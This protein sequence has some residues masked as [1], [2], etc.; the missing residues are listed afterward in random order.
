MQLFL[1]VLVLNI[2]VICEYLLKNGSNLN[3]VVVDLSLFL[4]V[5]HEF[6]SHI[7]FYDSGFHEVLFCV[8]NR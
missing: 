1:E 2:F 7:P 5:A 8:E 6:V 4:K 3:L